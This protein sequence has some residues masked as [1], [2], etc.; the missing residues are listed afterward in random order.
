VDVVAAVGAQEQPAAVVEPG[1]GAF[2]G[3]ALAAERN[4]T[5]NRRVRYG[6][7]IY[8]CKR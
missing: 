2:N 1:E 5:F 6:G 8:F 7:R 3:P 4:R